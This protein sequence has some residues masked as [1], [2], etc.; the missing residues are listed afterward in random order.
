VKFFAKGL[1][2]IQKLTTEDTEVHRGTATE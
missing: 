2:Q 1:D